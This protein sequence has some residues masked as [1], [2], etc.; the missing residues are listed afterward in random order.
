MPAD[1]KEELTEIKEKFK[2]VSSELTQCKCQLESALE[3]FDRKNSELQQ[4]EQAL[5]ELTK[6]F[7][8]LESE[9]NELEKI[10]IRY[11]GYPTIAI[12]DRIKGD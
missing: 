9:N 12:Y 7:T 6:N 11:I 10:K 8:M 1:L 3:N 2:V 5:N 4:K